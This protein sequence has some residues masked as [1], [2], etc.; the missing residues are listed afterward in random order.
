MLLNLKFEWVIKAY[1]DARLC[2]PTA[3]LAFC[4]VVAFLERVRQYAKRTVRLTPVS[5]I[6]N[7]HHLQT[8]MMVALVLWYC[9]SPSIWPLALPSLTPDA[10]RLVG[11]DRHTVICKVPVLRKVKWLCSG[12]ARRHMEKAKYERKKKKKERKWSLKSP[13]IIFFSFKVTNVMIPPPPP[14][15][16]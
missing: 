8:P 11:L 3:E 2:C 16:L 12:F 5:C 10:Y 13:N 7:P 6:G 15:S 1:W 4:S 9:C 14:S